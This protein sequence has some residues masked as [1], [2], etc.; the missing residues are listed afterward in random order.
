MNLSVRRV[1]EFFYHWLTP[2]FDPI[3][4]IRSAVGLRRYVKDWIS[5]SR[6]SGSD[7]LSLLDSHPQLNDWSVSTGIDAHYFY[8]SG[9][10]MRGILKGAPERH[11]DVGS[12]NLFVNLLSAVVPVD[13]VDIRPLGTDVPGLNSLSGSVLSM[14]FQDNSV[15]SLSCLHVAEHV[16]LGRYGDALDSNGTVKAAN[17]LGRILK[18]GGNLFFAIPIGQ[19]R[20]CF[21]AHRVISPHEVLTMFSSLELVEFSA[22]DDCGKFHPNGRIEGFSSCQYA[23]GMYWFRKRDER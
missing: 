11:V 22:V 19:P 15:K 7:T 14:P 13:F 4:A 23:C 17:E 8:M 3:R 18:P 5:Y 20:V 10:A 16:G 6:L 9:W 12:H 21:N 1:L 2:F